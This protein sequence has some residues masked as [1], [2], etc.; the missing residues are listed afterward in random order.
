MKDEQVIDFISDLHPDLHQNTHIDNIM[1]YLQGFC[2]ISLFVSS[3]EK[4]QNVRK[5]PVF[6]ALICT[7]NK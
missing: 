1:S 2:L 5:F 4:H 6:P 3:S 7:K